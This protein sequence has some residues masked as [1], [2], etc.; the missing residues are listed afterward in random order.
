MQTADAVTS[1]PYQW[2]SLDGSWVLGEPWRLMPDTPESAALHQ[3]GWWGLQLAGADGSFVAPYP[4]L[5]ITHLPRPV[6]TLKVVGDSARGEYPVDFTVELYAEDDTLLRS[7]AVEGNT[8]I[9]WSR[10]LPAPSPG[11]ARQVL[12]I[13]KWSHPGRQCKI[14]EFFTSVQETYLSGDIIEIRLLEEREANQGSLPV[15]NISANEVTVRLSNAD[16]RFDPDNDQSPLYGL[17]KPNRRVQLWLGAD[18]N[19]TMEWVPLGTFWSLDWDSPDD[20][21]EAQVRA[22]DRLEL[23]RKSTYQPR[24]VQQNVSLYTLAEQVLVDAG[25]KAG[26]Y[27]ID[28]ALAGSGGFEF[29]CEFPL[30]IAPLSSTIIPWGWLPVVSHRDALRII[31][32]AALAVVYTDRD[33]IIRIETMGSVPSTPVLTITKDDYFPPLQSPSR[34]DQV[35]NEIAVMTQPLQPAVTAQEVYRS[36]TPISIAAGQTVIV[37]AQYSQA[38]VIDA[39]ASLENPPAGVSITAATYYACGAEISIQN[40]GGSMASVILVITG[41]PLSVQGGE[42][43]TARDAVSIQ[44]NGVLCYEFPTNPLMQRSDQAQAIANALLASAKDSR[45]D[46]EV[47]WRGNPALELGDRVTVVNQDMYAIRQEITWAGALSARL[48]GRK[49]I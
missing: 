46:I 25:L 34:Q 43:I 10:V 16:H 29:P 1:V 33:G 32:E 15:G 30:D 37:R 31:A 26:E 13:T 28:P 22:R 2:A 18:I 12:T 48:T 8:E 41:N 39:M 38:P 4:A 36:A 49:A 21:L 9:E 14:V 17:L 19:G 7:D 27:W 35:A 45:R 44:E 42:R 23:L 11:V 6:H 5:T 24:A 47:E 20:A 3:V 40:T